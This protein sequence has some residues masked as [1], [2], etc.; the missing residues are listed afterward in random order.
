MKIMSNFYHLSN[1][2]FLC[3]YTL[4]FSMTY[5]EICVKVKILINAGVNT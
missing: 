2:I 3:P 5:R 1:A 4:N